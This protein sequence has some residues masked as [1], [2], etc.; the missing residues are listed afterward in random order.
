MKRI[1]FLIIF[2]LSSCSSSEFKD[3]FNNNFSFSKDMNF[4]EFR[5]KVKEYADQSSYP[6][7]EN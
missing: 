7:L 6:N 3:N 4:E 1:Y 5:L 2:T